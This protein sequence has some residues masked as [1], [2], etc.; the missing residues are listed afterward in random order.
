MDKDMFNLFITIGR[1]HRLLKD[2]AD[3]LASRSG[4]RTAKHWSDMSNVDDAFRLEEYVDA[5]LAN[6]QAVSWCLEL[7]LT[8]DGI[9]VEADVRR[10]HEEGQDVVAEIGDCEFQNAVDGSNGVAEIT[11]KLCASNPA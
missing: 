10:I 2:H 6:G 11:R 4:V 9:K 8:A 3:Q 1:C 7:T 5:E